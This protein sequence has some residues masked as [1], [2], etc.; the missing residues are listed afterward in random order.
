MGFTPL[1]N[2][3]RESYRR[4]VALGMWGGG[5]VG[6]V[7]VEDAPPC[8]IAFQGPPIHMVYPIEMGFTPIKKRCG[9]P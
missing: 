8:P 9:G 3:Y 1:R 6:H 7:G 5:F 4:K 2:C